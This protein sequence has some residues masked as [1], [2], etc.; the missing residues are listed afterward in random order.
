MIVHKIAGILT[1]AG[2]TGIAAQWITEY[3]GILFPIPDI[4]PIGLVIAGMVLFVMA[5]YPVIY[6]FDDPSEPH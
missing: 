5:P 1:F 4:L 3:Q 2:F 6:P